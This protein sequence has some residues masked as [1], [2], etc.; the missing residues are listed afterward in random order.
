VFR[1]TLS[2]LQLQLDWPLERCQR[3]NLSASDYRLE[4]ILVLPMVTRQW[5]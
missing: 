5:Q 1:P 4:Y 3:G 2:E